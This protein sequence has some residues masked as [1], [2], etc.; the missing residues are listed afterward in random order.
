MSSDAINKQPPPIGDHWF[1]SSETDTLADYSETEAD[2]SEIPVEPLEIEATSLDSV[3]DEVRK[4]QRQKQTLE[5]EIAELEARREKLIGEQ[6]GDIQVTIEQMVK[7]GLKELESRKGAL[8]ISVE[9]LERRRDRIKE[10]MRTTFAGASQDLAI[11]V[12]GFKDYLVGSLQDLA[13]SAE[14]LE[15]PNF[16]TRAVSPAPTIY[17]QKEAVPVQLSKPGGFE[18]KG[19]KIRELL[20]QYRSRPDYYGQPWQ[21]R[22][23]FEPIHSERVQNWFFNQGGRGTIRSMGSRLQNI[24]VASAIISVLN[25]TQGDRLRVLILASGPERLGEWRRGLQDCLGISRSDFAPERGIS[26]FESPEPLIQ[27]ADRLIEN[28]QTALIII[29]DT[30]DRVNMNLLQFPLW[31]AFA[32]DPQQSSSYYF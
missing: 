9:Q 12:Q 24:L 31:L 3:E 5:A 8:E 19:Q 15:L 14:Q 16:E 23:T 2:S 32:P 18:Q 10:E 20:D 11:R 22:R 30:E 21:L 7:I 26:L 1:E 29:D 13:A 17:S 25:Q 4:L 27:K 6:V 28:K